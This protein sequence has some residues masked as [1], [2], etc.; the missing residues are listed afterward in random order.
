[1]LFCADCGSTDVRSSEEPDDDW[2]GL[3]IDKSTAIP[4]RE[5]CEAW[6]EKKGISDDQ[7]EAA[8]L[9]MHTSLR[10]SDKKEAWMYE[11]KPRYDY[12]RIFQVWAPRQGS[13]NGHRPTQSSGPN[14]TV[15]GGDW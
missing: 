14:K 11:G 15:K 2:Y 5:H 4:S 8:A 10:W 3:L 9:A 1:M 7:A 13:S 6:L 12:W